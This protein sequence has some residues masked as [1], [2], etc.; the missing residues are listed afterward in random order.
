[1][2]ERVR[3]ILIGT[4]HPGNLGAAARA[5]KVMG[6]EELYLVSPRCEI[7]ELSR[8]MASKGELILDNVKIVSE[9]SEALDGVHIAIGASARIRGIDW[10]LLAPREA[11]LKHRES[12]EAN[13]SHRAAWVLGREDTGLTNQELAACQYHVHIPTS[14]EYSSL[15][16]AAALQVLAYES[17]LNLIAAQTEP[18]GELELADGKAVEGFFDHLESVLLKIGF[19]RKNDPKVMMIKVKRIFQKA[20]LEMAEVA[21]LRGVLSGLDR[22][23]EKKVSIEQENIDK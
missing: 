18:E 12:L 13:G 4:S 14:E 7:D 5:M 19:H 10:P 1:M 6:L 20:R 21:I 8:S 2:I 17:R 22:A 15:N 9:L 11:A 23:I 3:V 16:V